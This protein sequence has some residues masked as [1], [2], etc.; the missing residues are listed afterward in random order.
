MNYIGDYPEDHATVV[1]YFT[2]HD[3]TGAPV[4]PL[5]AFEAG[6]VLIYKDGNGAQK[7]TTNGLTMVSPFDSITGLHKL[8]IDTSN[9]TGD[10]GFW[11]TGS[12][13]TVILSPDSE[14]VEGI[15]VLK[16][17]A[18]FGI[19]LDPS[20]KPTTPGNKI[21]VDGSGNVN[22]GGGTVTIDS[23]SSTARAQVNA[24]CDTA[25]SDVGLTSVI[26]DRIDA[27]ISTRLAGASYTAPDNSS[28]TSIKAK[29]DNLPSDPA[30][31]S[32]IASSFSTVNTT[33][34][35]IG[36]YLDTEIAAIKAKTD[37]LPAAPA[38]VSD[39]PTANQNA[40]ALLDRSAGVETNLTVRQWLR[41]AAAAL[42]GKT[43]GTG[44]TVIYRDTNDSKDR[45]TATI[46][47]DE[48]RTTV[49]LDKS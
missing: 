26:T 47:D 1:I 39:I 34:G 18:S 30:D 12:S 27:A 46:D 14:T 22:A 28:I 3:S 42:F 29:T 13:Y 48:N 37:N 32:D 23:L 10:A 31:A 7:T 17:L 33:L 25:I 44:S 19:E 45:I 15:T 5:S 38:A 41:V 40:D 21:N 11:T 2:T 16:L 9:D 20:V 8:N 6:D 35:T 24:E 4:A 49:T 43:T 36:G